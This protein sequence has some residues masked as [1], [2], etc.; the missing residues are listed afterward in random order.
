MSPSIL[1]FITPLRAQAKAFCLIYPRSSIAVRQ[2][3]F[4]KGCPKEV[5]EF[6]QLPEIQLISTLPA[7]LSSWTT[8]TTQPSACSASHGTARKALT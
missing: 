7:C 2:S 5:P 6:L 1:R 3:R 4:V 8:T